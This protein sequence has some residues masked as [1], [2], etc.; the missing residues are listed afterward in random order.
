MNFLNK[1]TPDAAT[2]TLPA[3]VEQ[4]AMTA[5]PAV[6]AADGPRAAERFFTFFTDNIRNKNT[7]AAYYRNA[8]RF[9]VWCAARGARPAG[10]PELPRLGLHRRTGPES[11][12]PVG[13]AAPRDHPDAL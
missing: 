8:C 9:F 13:Q 2:T 5:I 10:R 7:R 11:R 4:T 3:T 1:P 6:I 12:G